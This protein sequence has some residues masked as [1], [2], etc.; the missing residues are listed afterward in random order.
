M[1][2]TPQ[3]VSSAVTLSSIAL[4]S[5][6]DKLVYRVSE[7]KTGGKQ[8]KASLWYASDLFKDDKVETSQIT[9]GQFNDRQ[10]SWHPDSKTIY[11]LS[12]RTKEEGGGPTQIYKLKVTGPGEPSIIDSCFKEKKRGVEDFK[13]SP[14]G[15]YIAFT[16]PVEPSPEEEKK[17]AEKDDPDVWGDTKCIEANAHLN[18][19]T[20]STGETKTLVDSGH[21]YLFSWSPDSKTLAYGLAT[22][23]DLDALYEQTTLNTISILPGSSPTVLR[24]FEV[25]PPDDLIWPLSQSDIYFLGTY[26]P[27][28]LIDATVV[29]RLTISGRSSAQNEISNFYAGTTE[30]AENFLNIGKGEIAVRIANG[31]NTRVDILNS[32]GRLFVLYDAKGIES[33]TGYDVKKL[34]DTYTFVCIRNSGPRKE[35]ANIWVGRAKKDETLNMKSISSHSPWTSSHKIGAVERFD[36]KGKDGMNLDGLV[37]F[38]EGLDSSKVKTPLPTV[39]HIHGGPYSRDTPRYSTSI[40]VWE[41]MLSENGYLVLLPNYRGSSG[42]GSEFAR[43]AHQGMGT[44]EWSDIDLMVDEAIKRGL[45]D[46]NKL[47][48]GGWS[49]GGFLTA[50][51]V[52]QTKSKFKCAVMG[53]GVSDWGTMSTESDAIQFEEAL[54]GASPWLGSGARL[55]GD[56]IRHAKDI[57]TAFL[58]V[59]GQN[60]LRVP[61]G[62]ASGF[63]RALRRVSKYP[64]RHTLVTYPREPHGFVEKKHGED[65]L[66][67]VLGHFEMWLNLGNLWNRKNQALSG[68]TYYNPPDAKNRRTDGPA[69]NT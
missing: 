5:D 4:S 28:R 62:Q 51:G 24:S 54:S 11:F 67:Q 35:P 53:A 12:D 9:S 1:A 57:E 29:N 21:V 61:V 39:V 20:I 36:W 40:F 17:E 32:E 43:A 13:I 44:I 26:H 2:F 66:K 49:Q 8:Q 34:D 56:P 47:G 52:S 58:I 65:L 14:D 46:P 6:G 23:S 48:I 50:W 19:Y 63:H 33:L 55:A 68:H 3:N 60:D 64:A 31:I 30:D 10:P 37:W 16:S 42:R 7:L 38:P 69:S 59:H 41:N 45:A 27:G 15:K 18:I 25:S 22:R